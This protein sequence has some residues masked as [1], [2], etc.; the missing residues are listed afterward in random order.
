MRYTRFFCSRGQNCPSFIF[1][2]FT[3]VV[4]LFPAYTKDKNFLVLYSHTFPGYSIPFSGAGSG[5][6][7][8]VLFFGKF[9]F[10]RIQI[11]YGAALAQQAEFA[12]AQVA[13]PGGF[14]AAVE[15]FGQEVVA[16]TVTLENLL[17]KLKVMADAIRASTT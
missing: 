3:G 16:K 2:C 4:Y 14:W 13:V 10:C 7:F 12:T 9:R 1:P 6:N 5:L 15:S 8:S 17:A 11:S